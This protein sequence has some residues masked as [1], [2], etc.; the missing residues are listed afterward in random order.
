ME[1]F[2]VSHVRYFTLDYRRF[3]VAPDHV[4]PRKITDEREWAVAP[5]AF[6]G[7]HSLDYGFEVG[8]TAGAKWS[9]MWI[10]PGRTEGLALYREP[11]CPGVLAADASVAVWEVS[12]RT[13][14]SALVG[15]RIEGVTVHYEPWDETEGSWWC[16]RLDL[17]IGGT[18][19]EVLEAEG[20]PDGTLAPSADNL[21]VRMSSTT[22]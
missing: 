5:Y 12:S 6:P 16:R 22:D 20:K 8:D 13:A 3:E 18:T 9:V 21:V 1:G 19:V 11:M 7:G 4:G 2:E 15:H 14:W 10:P 17:L